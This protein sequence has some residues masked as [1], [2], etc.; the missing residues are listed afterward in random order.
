MLGIANV[1]LQLTTT[2]YT[3]YRRPVVEYLA[4]KVGEV[5]CHTGLSEWFE[6]REDA[7]L[8]SLLGVLL[9]CVMS[10]SGVATGL[11]SSLSVQ[12][13]LEDA[14]SVAVDRAT[15]AEL[16]KC[17]AALATLYLDDDLPE[18]I[19]RLLDS[20]IV[21]AGSRDDVFFLTRYQT[22]LAVLLRKLAKGRAHSPFSRII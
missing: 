19:D 11:F 10:Q 18:P 8:Y 3:R 14:H 6:A 12:A 13:D 17:D 1:L 9:E 7:T 21:A 20:A 22:A 2:R 16:S 4:H 15:V 5:G